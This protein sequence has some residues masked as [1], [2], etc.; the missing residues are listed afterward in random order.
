[1]AD[2]Q[3]LMF[4]AISASRAGIL[5]IPRSC[6]ISRPPTSDQALI[7]LH[8]AP[9]QI[10][11]RKFSKPF[12]FVLA[13]GHLARKHWFSIALQLQSPRS[14]ASYW[15]PLSDVNAALQGARPPKIATL[16]ATGR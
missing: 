5:P 1:M 3:A 2:D 4:R 11:R 10:V 6:P 14:V 15:L 7:T 9:S 13:L 16:N 12:W 8:D